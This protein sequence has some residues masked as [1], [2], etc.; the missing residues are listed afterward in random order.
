[1]TIKELSLVVLRLEQVE[2][3]S[4]KSRE[5]PLSDGSSLWARVVLE[6]RSIFED[7][8]AHVLPNIYPE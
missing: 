3:T 2:S 6:L 7:G 4:V 1:M 5:I 8:R